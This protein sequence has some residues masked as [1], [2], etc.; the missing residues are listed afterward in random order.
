M[1]MVMRTL[2]RQTAFLSASHFIVRVLGFVLRIWLS[3]SL[4]AQTMGLVELASSAQ[5]LLI[6]PVISGLPAAVSRMCARSQQKRRVR[7]VRM[8][9]ALSLMISLPLTLGAFFMRAELSLWLG[10]I[11]TT[12]ALLFYL[13]CVP[14]LGVSCV[15]NGYFYG[16]GNPVPPAVCEL[17]EQIVRLLL[18]LKLTAIFSLYPTILRA[19]IPAAA[20]LLGETASLILMLLFSCRILISHA[21]GG[22]RQILREMLSLALPLTGMR[23]VTTLMRTVNTTLIPARLTAS[24]LPAGE[25][26]TQLGMM[27]GMLMPV[28]MLP[29][30]ITCSLTMVGA[31]ELTRRQAQGRPMRGLI[32]KLLTATLLIGFLSMAAAFLFA[33]LLAGR[34]YRQAELEPM[35][36]RWCIL[37]PVMALCQVTGGLMNGLG[38]QGQ[39]LRIC[40][41]SQ[42]LSVLICYT[43]AARPQLRLHGALI[44]M[45][46]GQ[47]LALSLNLTTLLREA[48]T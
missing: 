11:R 4:G 31:P 37:V 33:P 22:R 12:P 16:S 39:S 18:C 5:M 9:M 14:V 21:E 38:L 7:I 44:A 1:M 43:L 29:S 28:L 8:G 36:R 23:L 26:L 3:R 32:Q 34:L 42:F 17:F 46:A 13:P 2:L 27:N 48:K 45:A 41:G 25:A 47:L 19:A 40:I 10:D 35:I 6:A 30:F 15:L 24:G 20:S